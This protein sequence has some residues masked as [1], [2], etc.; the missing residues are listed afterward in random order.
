MSGEGDDGMD[1]ARWADAPDYQD[2]PDNVV[3]INAEA[4]KV[5][6]SEDAVALRFTADYG[7]TMRFDH[8]VGKWYQWDGTIWRKLGKPVAFQF[9]REIARGLGLRKSANAKGAEAFARADPTHAVTSEIWDADPMMLATPAGVIDL[10]NATS[11]KKPRPGWFMTKAT[12]VGPS[13]KPPTV[14][15]QFLNDAAAG[16][17]AVV[18][19]LQRICGYCLTGL[20]TEHALFFLHGPGGNGKSV[21]LNTLTYILGD[22]ATPAAMDTFTASKFNAH[23]TELAMLKGARLVTASETDEGRAW[24][25]A[26]IKMLTGG[27]LITAR[28]MRQDNFTFAPQFK[29]LF[30]GNHAP[31]LMNVDDAMRRRFNIIPFTNKPRS[32]D[33]YL[34]SKLRAE[35]EQILGW[36]IEGCRKWQ[37]SGLE[38]PD[39]VSDATETYFAGQDVFKQ[40]L[41]DN[42]R[43]EIGNRSLWEASAALFKDWTAYAKAAGEVPGDAVKFGS[44]IARHGPLPHRLAASSGK[45]RG[46]QYVMLNQQPQGWHDGQ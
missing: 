20:T 35:A 23:S 31:R 17:Q 3:P 30:V 27:D 36:M 9:A 24:A 4:R 44:A 13:S 18:D 22:Y 2:L 37:N 14:W 39:S 26:R 29:L 19:Y 25:E 8:D 6:A 34:E 10:R 15:L 33:R 7:D 46:Y 32:P 12:A 28:L 1:D 42:C 11:I 38:R 45:T 5:P 16:D 43:V 41:D 40:W 21:F